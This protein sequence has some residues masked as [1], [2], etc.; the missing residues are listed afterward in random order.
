VPIILPR[1]RNKVLQTVLDHLS[2]Q[3]GELHTL[4]KFIDIREW[5]G[6]VEVKAQLRGGKSWEDTRE[7]AKEMA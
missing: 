3:A 5:H 1:P 2:Y 7:G 4:E 6:T